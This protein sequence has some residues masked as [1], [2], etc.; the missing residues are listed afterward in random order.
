MTAP[1]RARASRIPA[2]SLLAAL[3]LAGAGCTAPPAADSASE[4]RDGAARQ[5]TSAP[6]AA[7]RIPADDL[8]LLHEAEQELQRRCMAAKGFRLWPVPEEP[9]PEARDFPYVVDDPAWAQRYGYGSSLEERAGHLRAEDP[10]RVYLRGLPEERR[11]AAI[12]ALNGSR[13]DPGQL[14]AVLPG[15]AVVGH[16]ATGCRAESWRELYGDLSGWF[17]ARNVVANLGAPRHRRVTAEPEYARSVAAWSACMEAAGLPYE[18]PADSRAE[19]LGED[20]PRDAAREKRAAV[21]EARCALSSGLSSVAARLDR[22]HDRALRREHR[23]AVDR[24]E[25]LR[26]AA[27]PRARDVLAR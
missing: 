13:S 8:G 27:L 3:L 26:A 18:D 5:D 23:T 14:R 11:Q 4:P 6:R 16:S 22:H 19:F 20:R 7:G 25:R 10:N 12:T 21:R 2:R 9:L 24:L 15:G 1:S 17:E